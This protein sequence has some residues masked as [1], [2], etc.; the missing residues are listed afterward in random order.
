M[1]KTKS[2]PIWLTILNR[3]ASADQRHRDAQ[4]LKS[5]SKENLADMGMTRED[6]NNAF[7]RDRY[8]RPVD[9]ARLPIARRA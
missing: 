5:L 8:S 7:L 1:T 2:T 9:S 6:A 4:K 3:I